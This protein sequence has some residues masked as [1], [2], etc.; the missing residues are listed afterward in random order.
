MTFYNICQ[1]RNISL[2]LHVHGILYTYKQ[3]I[4]QSDSTSY[5]E[6]KLAI[7]VTVN[8]IDK[9]RDV[10]NTHHLTKNVGIRGFPGGGGKTW[11]GLYCMVYAMSCGLE[12]LTTAAMMARC[13][14]LLGGI[15]WHK[16]LKITSNDSKKLTPQQIAELAMQN[17][18]RDPVALHTIRSLDI[19]L[20]DE[21]GQLS[22]EFACV[23]NQH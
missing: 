3:S 18:N 15:H 12:C 11:C 21:L 1:A 20:A 13:A 16:F 23:N 9:Y 7:S 19:I 17:I 8:A 4:L 14:S 22:A 6:Q 5:E 10:T 2:K